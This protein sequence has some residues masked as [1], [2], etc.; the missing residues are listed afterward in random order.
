MKRFLRTRMG[1][2]LTPFLGVLTPVAAGMAFV[3][4]VASFQEIACQAP[5]LSGV[6]GANGWGGVPSPEQDDY[7]AKAI[8]RTDGEGLR[9]YLRRWPKGAYADEAQ[10]RLAGCRT[11]EVETWVK[12]QRT[13]PMYVPAGTSAR[14]TETAARQQ[15][16][17]AA[18]P[19]A[20]RL[21]VGFSSGEFRLAGAEPKASKWNCT[22]YAGGKVC[23]FEGQ[24]VCHVEARR[25]DVREVCRP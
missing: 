16:L 21:C 1:R 23:G 2:M 10:A 3:L 13:L 19:D 9:G 14:P 20:H 12:D 4:D 15:A 11:R 17:T 6:C 24:A 7:W 25:M 22:T 18:D 8:A 5:G